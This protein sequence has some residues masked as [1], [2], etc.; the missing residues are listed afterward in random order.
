MSR[1]VVKIAKRF[2]EGLRK[3]A[4]TKIPIPAILEELVVASAKRIKTTQVVELA[5]TACSRS[6]TALSVSATPKIRIVA[7]LPEP[8]PQ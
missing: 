4:V 1:V 6:F 2:L 3:A 5:A 7:F 8:T